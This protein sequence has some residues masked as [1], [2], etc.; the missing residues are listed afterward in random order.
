MKRINEQKT[1]EQYL[2]GTLDQASRKVF[3]KR[4]KEEPELAKE[5]ALWQ[6]ITKGIETDLEEHAPI[7]ISDFQI[8]T[9]LDKIHAEL[10]DKGF[11]EEAKP[12]N[13]KEKNSGFGKVIAFIRKKPFQSLIAAA[14]IGILLCL[15]VT[16]LTNNDRY[17]ALDQKVLFEINKRG[18]NENEM[19]IQKLLQNGFDGYNKGAYKQAIPFF[20]EAQ[21]ISNSGVLDSL[22]RKYYYPRISIYLACAY[23]SST[24]AS[25]A[26]SCL[27]SVYQTEPM[28]E[29][30]KSATAWYLARAYLEVNREADAVVLWDTLREDAVYGAWAVEEL[31]EF[32]N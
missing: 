31:N 24:Q 8:K 22:A 5:V 21:K 16:F 27:E 25:K 17:A 10:E 12:K 14:I 19:K 2:D 3:E 13:L 28:I 1:I 32:S 7:A 15:P 11:Y 30:V 23:L 18:G 29:K 20:E 4:I 26:I 9:G 6:T